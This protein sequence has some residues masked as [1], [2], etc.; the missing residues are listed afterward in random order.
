MDGRE[1]R[2]TPLKKPMNIEKTNQILNSHYSVESRW[3]ENSQQDPC[4]IKFGIITS[5]P[6]HGAFLSVVSEK[7]RAFV[8]LPRVALLQQ[9]KKTNQMIDTFIREAKDTLLEFSPEEIEEWYR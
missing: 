7:E 1:Q 3:Q 9:I 8:F 6:I 4:S 5:S 2:Q